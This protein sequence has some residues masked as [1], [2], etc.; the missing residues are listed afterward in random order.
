[1][2]AASDRIVCVR[3]G[4]GSGNDTVCSSPSAA[5]FK[6]D[7]ISEEPKRGKDGIIEKERL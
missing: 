7:E 4:A 2:C 6:T 3:F 5:D 1:M